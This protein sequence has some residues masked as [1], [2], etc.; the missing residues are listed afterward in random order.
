MPL[1]MHAVAT[2]LKNNNKWRK[3]AKAG[4]FENHAKGQQPEI[5]FISCADS[6]VTPTEI[7]QSKLGELF[8][9]RRVANLV[10]ASDEGMQAAVRYAVSVLGVKH[11]VVCG[12]Y[13]CGGVKAAMDMV[14][15]QKQLPSELTP[16]LQN[17]AKVYDAHKAELSSIEDET[18]RYKALIR[19]NALS[20]VEQLKQ[21]APITEAEHPP[22]LHS[23]IYDI[24]TGKVELL[25]EY[26]DSLEAALDDTVEALNSA[27][28]ANTSLAKVLPQTMIL[29]QLLRLSQLSQSYNPFNFLGAQSKHN[30]IQRALAQA[31]DDGKDL[32]VE[33]NNPESDLYT[34]LNQKRLLPF[35]FFDSTQ[36]QYFSSKAK[37]LIDI[38]EKSSYLQLNMTNYQ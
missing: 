1:S 35:S 21:F 15:S 14:E 2:L 24:H 3:K 28:T 16:W 7:T 37:T 38:E 19:L 10:V 5:F 11:V 31:M 33:L 36:N 25:G 32:Q 34:A 22:L 20:Q 18:E 30:A 13:G 17:V 29:E 26:Q 27:E 9:E 6:R 4:F 12:H 8:E 23:A